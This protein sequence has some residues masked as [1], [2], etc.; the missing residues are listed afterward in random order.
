MAY[1]TQA[2]RNTAKTAI[3]NVLAG[4]STTPVATAF[5][6]GVNDNGTTGLTISV[7]CNNSDADALRSALAPAWSSAAR[8]TTGHYIS[9]TKES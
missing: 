9:V 7:R 3:N 4:Y 5:A 2:N 8:A 6:A 1:T